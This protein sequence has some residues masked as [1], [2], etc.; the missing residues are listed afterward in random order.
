MNTKH[1]NEQAIDS[2]NTYFNDHQSSKTLKPNERLLNQV[3]I[4]NIVKKEIQAKEK[5][6]ESLEVLRKNIAIEAEASLKK[7]LGEKAVEKPVVKKTTIEDMN[8]KLQEEKLH[9]IEIANKL[10]AVKLRK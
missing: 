4:K 3:E 5:K 1:I 10:K 6:I 7:V 9:Q 8:L 2:L